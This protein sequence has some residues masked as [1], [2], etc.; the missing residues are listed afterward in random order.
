MWEILNV[1]DTLW[2]ALELL[3]EFF[4]FTAS[5]TDQGEGIAS[6]V[7][8]KIFEPFFSTKARGMGLG[9]AISR[10]ILEKNRGEMQ[11]SSQP[12]IGSEFTVL[13]EAA[14]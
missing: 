14:Q 8:D 3:D 2:E 12:G 13:L 10:V 7:L 11:V 1:R 4:D 9:L 6:D 5:F